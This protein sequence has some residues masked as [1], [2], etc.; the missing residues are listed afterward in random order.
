M[1]ATNQFNAI[2]NGAKNNTLTNQL[3]QGKTPISPFLSTTPAPS[4][5]V[6]PAASQPQTI[7]ASGNVK[8]ANAPQ[9]S[10]DAMNQKLGVGS[11]APKP[12][13]TN[14]AAGPNETVAAGANTPG[15]TYT[16]GILSSVGGQQTNYTPPP[17]PTTP[18]KKTTTTNADGSATTTEY[19]AP[20]TQT[21]AGTSQTPTYAGLVTS[22]AQNSL[23]QSPATATAA[24][25]LLNAPTQNNA[26]SNEAKD[27]R[28]TYGGQI[29]KIGAL[30]AGATAGDLST[31][32]DVVGSG[33]AAIA[34]QSASERMNALAND[35]AQQI[36]SLNPELTAQNQGQV[37]LTSAG[38]LGNTAQAQLQSGLTS[39]AGAA[40]PQQYSLTNQPY[41]PVQ[42]TYGGGGSG[43][44]L[45]RANL[46]GQVAGAE[47]AGAAP[48][49]AQAANTQTAGTAGVQANQ[50]VFTKAYG[51]YKT[52]ENAVGN[53][54]Q[55]GNL[56]IQNMGGINPSDARYANQTIAQ[57]RGQLSSPQQAQ[58]DTTLAALTSK[59]SGLLSVGGNEIPTD[60]S[61]A[62]NKIIDGSLPVGSLTAV[63]GR[64]Q[65]EGNIL[66]QNQ[67]NLVNS[68]YAGLGGSSSTPA[69]GQT[70]A[71]SGAGTVSAGGYSFKQ[72]NGQWVPVQ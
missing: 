9:S 6:K 44:V 68:S 33:N 38:N 69:S 19:H 29:A 34:S 25:G 7:A 64:I 5:F 59:V 51:D 39:A 56:L 72:V 18:V 47:A 4:P 42:D 20:D 63:L 41:N 52:L 3:F 30:G 61:A 28:N 10:A 67:G 1:P 2:L 62:A 15:Y 54:D 31:G 13:A 45:D 40:A 27:I 22:L 49:N 21:T 71:S 70:S 23:N 32:T 16:N 48:G 36:N 12:T 53:V 55:F 24:S 66:L 11:Y 17:A 50:Q 60:I 58:F 65:Q 26:I 14:P 43:G 35:E 8:N 57:I 46:A 37:G